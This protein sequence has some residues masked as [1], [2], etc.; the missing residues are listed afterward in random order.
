KFTTSV[1]RRSHYEEVSGKNLLFSVE[2]EWQLLI[3]T[4]YFGSR[5]AALF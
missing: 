2:N 5:F 4:V 1:F 3:M